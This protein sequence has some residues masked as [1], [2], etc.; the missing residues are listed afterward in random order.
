MIA[1]FHGVES[2]TV[3]G[4]TFITNLTDIPAQ[5]QSA[6]PPARTHAAVNR[7]WPAPSETFSVTNTSRKDLIYSI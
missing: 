2:L 1:T 5:V 4:G 7:K 3:N 6:R